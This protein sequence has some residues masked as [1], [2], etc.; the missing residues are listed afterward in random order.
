M[1]EEL[2]EIMG[3]ILN[4]SKTQRQELHEQLISQVGTEHTSCDKMLQ[5]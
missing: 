1:T 3:N 5:D 2:I 4:L